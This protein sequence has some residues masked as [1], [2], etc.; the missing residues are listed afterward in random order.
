MFRDLLRLYLTD[1]GVSHFVGF[2]MLGTFFPPIFV[3][4]GTKLEKYE[5]K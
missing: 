2:G 1:K 4:N 5:N 3:G